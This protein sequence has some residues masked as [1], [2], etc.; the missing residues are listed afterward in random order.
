MAKEGKTQLSG[1]DAFRLY[2]TY[3]FP[4][5]LTTE[6]LQEKG[7]SV[8]EDGFAACMKSRRTRPAPRER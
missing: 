2:D 6:I 4:L 3:G 8:D 5:D 7:F 1:Q